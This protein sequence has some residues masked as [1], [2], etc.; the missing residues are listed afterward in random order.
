MTPFSLSK[1]EQ[2]E[3]AKRKVNSLELEIDASKQ[4][5]SIR[6]MLEKSPELKTEDFS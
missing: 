4:A 2:L 3:A 5:D 1:E 6:L